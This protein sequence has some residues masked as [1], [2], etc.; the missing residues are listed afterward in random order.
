[1]EVFSVTI[2]RTMVRWIVGMDYFPFFDF[3]EVEALLL[4]AFGLAGLFFALALVFAS[5]F[6]FDVFFAAALGG[7]ASALAAVFFV[8]AFTS[9]DSSTTS[10][11]S[12][13]A[14]ASMRTTSDHRMW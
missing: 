12:P 11:F 4:D 13:S 1:M 6:G 8:A 14:S 5:A 7:L 9:A 10:S 3:F 2:G